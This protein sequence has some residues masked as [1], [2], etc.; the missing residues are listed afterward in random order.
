MAKRRI[1]ALEKGVVMRG[2]SKRYGATIALDD[3]DFSVA[4]GEA[5]ALLGENGAG[6]STLTKIL[7]GVVVPDSGTTT[8]DGE[9]YRPRDPFDAVRRGVSMIHQELAVAPHLT[10]EENVSLGA[11]PKR[12]FLLDRG[13]IRR[14]AEETLARFD[15]DELRPDAFAG[16]LSVGARQLVEIARALVVG[17]RVLL[18]DEPTGSLSRS[19][20]A[21]LFDVVR[22][23]KAEGVAIVYISHF[24][25]ETREV[26]DRVVVLRDGRKVGD[27]RLDE[28]DDREIVRMMVGKDVERM[29]PFSMRTPRETLLRVVG[30]SGAR[31]PIDASLELR[32]GE[33][34]G[35]AGLVGA[36]RTELLRAIFGLDEV[37]SGEVKV[38]LFEGER[39]PEAMWDNGVGFVSED[40]KEEGLALGLSVAENV[41]LPSLEK[42]RR[43]RFLS[44]RRMKAAVR[45]T[46]D[47]LDVKVASIDAPAGDL[48]GGNQQKTAIARLL[49][50]EADVLLL[51]EPTRGVDVGAKAT[52]YRI[53]D[54]LVSGARGKPRGAIVV[55]GYMPEL[56]GVCD[57]IAVMRR[58][59]L[60]PAL[61]ASELDVE[62][63]T[64][65][66]AG[67][68]EF[69]NYCARANG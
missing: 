29:Y 39:T 48:S 34:L 45:K 10:V 17:G 44:P 52:I 65:A 53:L 27:R 43:G 2:V 3:V 41:A 35:V 64:H 68:R 40:R 46:I 12:G 1:A 60:S 23:L 11:E 16:D 42:H 47:D 4:P 51:D 66:A 56:L 62:T 28:I 24:L 13:E 59:K 54:E 33:I 26:A 22:E 6:K 5:V 69:A 20:A 49:A 58:G 15:N 21:K 30:A 36:G 7:A 61:P 9:P 14:R 57:R 31:K 19:D 32:R 8:L 50:S 18:L 38:A 63:L 67:E 37:T 55:G 25:E